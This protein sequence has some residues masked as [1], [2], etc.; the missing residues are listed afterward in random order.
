MQPASA[1]V[2]A[3]AVAAGFAVDVAPEAG[4]ADAEPLVRTPAKFAPSTSWTESPRPAFSCR[5]AP[6]MVAARVRASASL[7]GAYRTTVRPTAL[8]ALPVPV[9]VKPADRSADAVSVASP[10]RPAPLRTE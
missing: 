3:G 2:R 6:G 9:T 8:S 10:R 7:P 5:S 1:A 4:V